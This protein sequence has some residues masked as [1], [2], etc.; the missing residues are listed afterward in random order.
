MTSFSELIHSVKSIY[1]EIQAEAI[2]DALW[3]AAF[4]DSAPTFS[5]SLGESEYPIDYPVS[6]ANQIDRS[7]TSELSSTELLDELPD[8]IEPLYDIDLPD[9]IENSP[10]DNLQLAEDSEIT[11]PRADI[12]LQD[13][14]RNLSDQTQ[15]IP[16]RTPA[17]SALNSD[18]S[19]R[20]AFR[21][22]GRTV[23]S[24]TEQEIDIDATVHSI[25][26]AGRFRHVRDRAI[27]PPE[28]RPVQT[29]WLDLDF[30]VDNWSSMA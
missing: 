25:A 29:R 27:Q 16:F 1:P 2:A 26:A 9:N 14:D 6:V 19:I 5:Q 23:P 12:F 10:G 8:S 17:V 20:K 18:L 7:E 4:L 28:L 3:L 13:T 24:R 21:P 15:G 11:S 30:V 22:L